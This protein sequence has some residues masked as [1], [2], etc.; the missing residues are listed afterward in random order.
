MSVQDG[1]PQSYEGKENESSG[2]SS[3]PEEVLCGRGG[4]GV[5]LGVFLEDNSPHHALVKKINSKASGW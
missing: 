1:A 3:R 4:I 2:L 5:G